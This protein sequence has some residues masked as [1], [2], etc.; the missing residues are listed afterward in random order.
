MGCGGGGANT[1]GDD[2]PPPPPPTPKVLHG[3]AMFCPTALHPMVCIG[4]LDEESGLLIPDTYANPMSM[5]PDAA[6][7]TAIQFALTLPES[8]IVEFHLAS[9][10]DRN[11]DRIF[12]QEELVGEWEYLIESNGESWWA[13]DAFGV[14]P[15]WGADV[16]QCADWI[17]IPLQY[18]E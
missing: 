13:Q 5:P 12:Q 14:I 2:P 7:A 16:T 9:F 3:T 10:D 15:E 6:D 1:G 4:T 17:I 18:G 8:T 11:A